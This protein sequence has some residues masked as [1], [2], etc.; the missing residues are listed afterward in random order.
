MGLGQVGSISP[1][2]VSYSDIHLSTRRIPSYEL[3]TLGKACWNTIFGTRDRAL[4]SYVFDQPPQISDYHCS[5][6]L[7]GGITC[8]VRP[9]VHRCTPRTLLL[10]CRCSSCRDYCRRGHSLGS[11]VFP[12]VFVYLKTSGGGPRRFGRDRLSLPPLRFPL[13]EQQLNLCLRC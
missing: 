3:V 11:A 1:I 9:L 6:I 4:R 5:S 2:V 8:S 10:L 13:S 7:S 12:P